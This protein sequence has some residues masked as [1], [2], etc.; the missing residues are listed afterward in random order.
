L[1]GVRPPVPFFIFFIFKQTQCGDHAVRQGR[2][3][4]VQKWEF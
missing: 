1:E 2:T 4:F 3:E